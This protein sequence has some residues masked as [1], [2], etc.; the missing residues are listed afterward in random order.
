LSFVLLDLL[1]IKA[2]TTRNISQDQ[3]VYYIT[4]CGIFRRT[5]A[6]SKPVQPATVAI[7]P[8]VSNVRHENRSSKLFNWERNEP[9]CT[10]MKLYGAMPK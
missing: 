5:R 9:I 3:N 6:T 10:V 2:I 4:V 7:R 8:S 1:I